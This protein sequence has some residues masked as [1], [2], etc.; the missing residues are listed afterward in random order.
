MFCANCS[1]NFQL[2]VPVPSLAGPGTGTASNLI[3]STPG[4]VTGMQHAPGQSQ[5]SARAPVPVR[6]CDD[7]FQVA[8]RGP[9][10]GFVNVARDSEPERDSESS[11]Q[12]HMGGKHPA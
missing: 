9:G 12:V 7:C 4:P 8:D 11:F 3:L 2:P 1:S 6:V 5:T 10:R